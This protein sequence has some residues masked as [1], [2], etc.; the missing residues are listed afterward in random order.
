MKIYKKDY[1]N[2]QIANELLEIVRCAAECMIWLNPI[3][4][5]KDRI[6]NNIASQ[7]IKLLVHV[8]KRRPT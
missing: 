1:A 3:Y 8:E 7:L 5:T 4:S 6:K 2:L